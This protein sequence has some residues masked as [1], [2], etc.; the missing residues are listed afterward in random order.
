MDHPKKTSPFC[1]D[2]DSLG[3]AT[4]SKGVHK[5]NLPT[6]RAPCR[7]EGPEGGGPWD[8]WLL[9]HQE[10]DLKCC[11]SMRKTPRK[12]PCD[13]WYVSCM[14]DKYIY[15]CLSLCIYIVDMYKYI[16][17]ILVLGQ[18]IHRLEDMCQNVSY[19]S[20]RL[21]TEAMFQKSLAVTYLFWKWCS[22]SRKLPE[23][24]KHAIKL[25]RPVWSSLAKAKK[26]SGLNSFWSHNPKY[27]ISYAKCTC[28]N[29]S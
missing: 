27:R 19:T 18:Y 5:T 13:V 21:G 17:I 25:G 10:S 9:K 1:F 22:S 3:F 16:Y 24:S 20:T 4:L 14:F 12:Y 8:R 23:V 2:L 29:F 7:N 6:Q 11:K 15:I 28:L 26:K